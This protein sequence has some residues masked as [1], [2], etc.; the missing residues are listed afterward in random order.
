[1]QIE[2]FHLNGHT[3][4][5]HP[6]T[7]KLGPP[8]KTLLF[9]LAVKGLISIIVSSTAAIRRREFHIVGS[10][11]RLNYVTKLQNSWVF[12]SQGKA[13]SSFL[14]WFA[15]SSSAKPRFDTAVDRL[16]REMLEVYKIMLKCH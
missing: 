9:T 11:K 16:K 3:T 14:G 2:R 8:Y 1:M 6:Q 12:C 5:F 10:I 13:S 7:Q 15:L 4:G